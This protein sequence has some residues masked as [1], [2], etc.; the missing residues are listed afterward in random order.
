[1]T[2]V[3][4]QWVALRGKDVADV[5]A[6]AGAHGLGLSLDHVSHEGVAQVV[7]E[8]GPAVAG[9]QLLAERSRELA[10]LDGEGAGGRVHAAIILFAND[11]VNLFG[12]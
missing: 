7:A 9:A 2:L 8:G 1:M 4:R 3:V 6:A 11:F 10:L 5:P 12:V